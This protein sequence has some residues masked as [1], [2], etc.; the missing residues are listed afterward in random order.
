MDISIEEMEVDIEITTKEIKDYRDELEV[1][2]RNPVENKV[3]IY[4]LEG[5]IRQGKDL[6]K[7][8]KNF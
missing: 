5:F 4:F 6:L 7:E 3:R 8:Y 1:L 2:N